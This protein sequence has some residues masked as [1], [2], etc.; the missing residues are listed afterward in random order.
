MNKAVGRETDSSANSSDHYIGVSNR[1][2]QSSQG[3]K[4]MNDILSFRQE[5]LL[6]RLLRCFYH[7]I[8]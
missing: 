3:N 8:T 6:A 1:K 7:I 2:C 5:G 4:I